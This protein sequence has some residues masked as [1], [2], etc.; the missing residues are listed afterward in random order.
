M[1]VACTTSGD[2]LDAPLDTRFGRAPKFLVYDTESGEFTV[3]DNAQN[4]QAAQGAGVQAAQFVAQAG[5]DALITG[6]CG[7]KAFRV[8]QAAGVVVYN[9]D[10]PTVGEALEAL[11]LGRLHEAEGADVESHW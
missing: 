5:A 9:A 7:P 3:L 1:R 8:L 4:L 6:H 10:L 11:K 2:T